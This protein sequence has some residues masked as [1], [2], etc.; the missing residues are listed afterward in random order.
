MP[1]AP[2]S[3]PSRAARLAALLVSDPA[4]IGLLTT[5]A[6]AAYDEG[7]VRGCRFLLDRY[8]DEPSLTAELWN[9]KGLAALSEAAFDEAAQAFEAALAIAS[10]PA[11]RFNL[12]YVRAMQGAFEQALELASDPAL[13][14]VPGAA[15]LRLRSL[16]HLG[17]LE[18]MVAFG[19][20]TLATQSDTEVAGLL[21][22]GLFDAGDLAQAR[23]LAP[24]ALDSSDGCTVAGMLALDDGDG[25][26]AMALFAQ[27]L[28][29]RPQSGRALLGQGLA[30]LNAG[31]LSAAADAL[32]RA[33]GLMGAHAGTWVAAGWAYLL[34]SEHGRALACFELAL[35]ADRGFSEASGGLAVAYLAKND[36]EQAWHYAEVALRLDPNSLSGRYA[37]SLLLA[38]EGR[39][40]DADALYGQTLTLP[41]GPEER[42]IAA[43]LARRSGPATTH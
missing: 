6:T 14:D 30:L 37:K 34:Q 11:V 43:A 2:A 36:L 28:A 20:E 32:E 39:T 24:M 25:Q 17:R 38:S 3:T 26:R 33:S 40:H 22:T 12:A 18:E 31:Q 42:T 19:Q 4:N 15:A 1:S 8:G 29:M 5:A 10:D 13:A 41:I 23:A 27:A 16:H 9:L 35:A 7:D 21:A